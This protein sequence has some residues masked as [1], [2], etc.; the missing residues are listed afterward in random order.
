M[1]AED[2]KR[3]EELRQKAIRDGDRQSEIAADLVLNRTVENR[4]MNEKPFEH[5]GHYGTTL[6]ANR[7]DFQHG[8]AITCPPNI[9]DT[10]LVSDMMEIAAWH[11]IHIHPN[12]NGF[13][14]YDCIRIELRKFTERRA[15]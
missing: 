5:T 8:V 13:Q 10:H 11:A 15:K 3:F 14:G 12:L 9:S 6:T 7:C 1:N 4:W 2:T